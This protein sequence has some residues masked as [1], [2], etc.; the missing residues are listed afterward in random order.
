M[1]GAV[2]ETT[3]PLKNILMKDNE[4]TMTVAKIVNS[5]IRHDRYNVLNGIQD[6]ELDLP[7]SAVPKITGDLSKEQMTRVDAVMSRKY[8]DKWFK[9]RRTHL[10]LQTFHQTLTFNAASSWLSMRT[11]LT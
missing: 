11:V 6:S 3:Q 9:D 4:F 10:I 1:F 7:K 5:R 8:G 2:T